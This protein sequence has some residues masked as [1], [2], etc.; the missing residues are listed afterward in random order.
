MAWNKKDKELLESANEGRK[1]ERQLI[2]DWLH[3]LADSY[4]E[5]GNYIGE[6][7]INYVALKI[8]RGEHDEVKRGNK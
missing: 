6:G 5:Q 8:E 4:N 1:L 2:V 3:N 7:A